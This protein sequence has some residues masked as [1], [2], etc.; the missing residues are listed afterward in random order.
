MENSLSKYPIRGTVRK[1]VSLTPYFWG[2][3]LKFV[4]LNTRNGVS[5]LSVGLISCSAAARGLNIIATFNL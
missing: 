4:D 3:R 2:D 1:F 5:D